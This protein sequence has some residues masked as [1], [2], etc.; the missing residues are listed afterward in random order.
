MACKHASPMTCPVCK[1]AAHIIA[2]ED[3]VAEIRRDQRFDRE[4]ADTLYFTAEGLDRLRLW[5]DTVQDRDPAYMSK[6]D[7]YMARRIHE[8]LGL[9]VPDSIT[10]GCKDEG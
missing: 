3:R 4:A 10:E 6:V 5:F 7:Y 2:T 1:E 8:C 9:R